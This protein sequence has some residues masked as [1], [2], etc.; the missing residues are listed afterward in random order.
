MNSRSTACK[1]SVCA[2]LACG[3][4][5]A[6]FAQNAAPVKA[7]NSTNLTVAISKISVDQKKLV[8]QFTLKNNSKGRVY[9][10]NAIGD[11]KEIWLPWLGGTISRAAVPE[12]DR[13]VR[14]DPRHV[15]QPG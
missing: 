12:R 5:G 6:A 1:L 13:Q 14:T 4:P 8:F 15:Q 7:A 2:L 3:T 11:R 10:V 9:V